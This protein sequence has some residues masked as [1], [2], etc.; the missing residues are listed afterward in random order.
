MQETGDNAPM[1]EN[2]ENTNSV[3]RSKHTTSTESVSP[4]A[5]RLAALATA[6][7][8]DAQ[9]ALILMPLRHCNQVILYF[10]EEGKYGVKC[11]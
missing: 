5:I 1:H 9:A 3:T 2:P 11:S 4:D 6:I 10:S 7:V 8:D